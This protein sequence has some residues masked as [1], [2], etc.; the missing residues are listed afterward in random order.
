MIS[1]YS[2]I[3]NYLITGDWDITYK[4]KPRSFIKVVFHFDVFYLLPESSFGVYTIAK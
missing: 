2:E 1:S 4:L 3:H